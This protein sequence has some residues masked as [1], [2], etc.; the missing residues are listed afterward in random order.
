[1]NH[2]PDGNWLN[3][4]TY[5]DCNFTWFIDHRAKDLFGQV[6]LGLGNETTTTSV[7]NATG[8]GCAAIAAM[9][10]E[11]Q[12]LAMWFFTYEST[13]A[14]S[15]IAFC[16][17]SIEFWR[18]K[19]TVD[20]TTRNLTKVDPIAPL[21]S[22]DPGFELSGSMTGAPL[23]G[24]A[25]NG[26]AFNTSLSSADPFVVARAGSTVLQLPAAVM[27]AARDSPVGLV[28]TFVTDGFV[29]LSTRVLVSVCLGSTPVFQWLTTD[30]A[31]VPASVRTNRLLCRGEGH[32]GR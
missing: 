25:Y 5:Q 27:Q 20:L 23:N 29:P 19:A 12:P 14:N 4:A 24:K 13:P 9:P 26:A 16:N 15:S 22:G 1:M 6:A 17:P 28:G 8:P 11:Q 10:Q 2:L 3:S 31:N 30:A 21:Q 32:L 18:V 7:T